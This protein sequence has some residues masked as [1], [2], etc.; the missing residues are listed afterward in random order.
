MKNIYKVLIGIATTCVLLVA[1]D[2]AVGTWSEK[3]YYSSKYGMYRRQV[4]VMKEA[5]EDLM[6]MG[7]SRA[8][9]HYVPQILEDSLGMSCYNAGSDGECIYYHYCLLSAMIERG[10]KPKMVIYEVM[11]LD[12]EVSQG[13]TFTQDAALDR[14]AP[15]YGEFHAVDSLFALNG[16]KESV[17]MC[18]KTY[19]YNSKLVQTIKC[20]Y[21]QEKEDR[22]YEAM[23]GVMD[24]S[25]IEN[26]SVL[27]NDE[28]DSKIEVAKLEYMESFIGLCKK[29][30]IKLILC[31]SP[32]YNTKPSKGVLCI[33]D[34]AY[35]YNVPFYDFSTLEE[36][37]SP[38]LFRDVMHLND[39]GAKLFTKKLI[40]FIK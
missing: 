1:V 19:R 24:V 34:L 4:Y 8:A 17:K 40:L 38:D 28:N 32:Y 14:L 30:G 35:R 23:C 12:A 6:I 11:N 15:H 10:A 26:E 37:N 33:R 39:D 27:F 5:N 3:I 29:N 16:W 20:N 2:W 36:L 31:F 21:L 9:H 25:L 7:S 22:G 18:S 13:A